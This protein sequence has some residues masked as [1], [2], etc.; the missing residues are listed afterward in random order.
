MKKQFT[1]AALLLLSGT[2]F[3]QDNLEVRYRQC[4]QCADGLDATTSNQIFTY[5]GLNRILC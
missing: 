4:N 1:I 5:G 2:A 3:A